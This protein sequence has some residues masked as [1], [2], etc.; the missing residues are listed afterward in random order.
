MADPYLWLEEVE[1]A[2]AL[3]FAKAESTRTLAHFEKDPQFAKIKADLTKIALAEDKLPGIT[4]ING[5]VYNFWQD[6]KHVRGIWRRTSVSEF[7]K[8][9]PKWET[10]LDLDQLAKDENEN[11]VWGWQNCL[12]PENR[13]CL[14]TLSRGGKDASV[15]REFDLTTKA[16]VKDGFTLP[17][18]K[19]DISWI[20]KD[21]VF[22]GTDFG[23]GSLTDSGYPMIS[24]IWKRG[25]P[26]KE[27]KEVFK[28][29]P[30]DMSASSFVYTTENK[31][32]RFHFRVI[33]FYENEIWY[34]DEQGLRTHLPLPSSAQ[35]SGVFNDSFLFL[36]R[37]DLKTKTQTIPVGSLVALPVSQLKNKEKALDSLEVLFTPSAKRFLNSV[38]VSKSAIYLNLLDNIQGKIARIT[39]TEKGWLLEDLKMGNQGVARVYSADPWDDNYLVAY[40]DFLTPSSIYQGVSAHKGATWDLLKQAPERFKSKDLIVEQRHAKSADGTMIPYFI[41]HKK[42]LVLNGKNPTLLYGYGG[43]ESPIQPFYLDS[44]GKLWLER[45]GVYVAANLR[46]GGEFGPTWHRSVMRENRPKVYEDFIAIGEDLIQHKITSATHL[47]IQGRSNGGLLTGATFVK[48]PDLFNAVLCEV[49]LLDMA[50][51]HKLLA[52]ASWMEEYGNPDDSKMNDVLMSYSPYQNVKAQVKYPEVLFMTSTKDDRVH[53][54]HARKMVAR[55]KEQ[56][57]KIYYYENTEGGHAGNA[58]IQQK[59]LWNTLEYTYLWQKLSGKN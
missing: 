35:M 16:F 21:T 37:E 27:A 9:K 55:M 24:K 54:G 19:S 30:Q 58:N 13:L 15:V 1:G 12:P 50:R 57:H 39:H 48:R 5:E 56:G 43:F 31:K 59:I 28:G 17:E 14:L 46:G 8:I 26:L 6:K 42:N 29:G 25:Q 53:P 40:T 23:P 11:W 20:D 51:Y 52:G 18:A 22:V 34:E 4:L 41:V 38:E 33:S 44:I 32:Y 7:K 10:I 49:P 36:L 3:A 47:G 45:G 2:Q